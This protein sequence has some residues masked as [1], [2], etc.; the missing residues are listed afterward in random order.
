VPRTASLAR[1]IA[2]T[3]ASPTPSRQ[4]TPFMRKKIIAANWK[5]NMTSAEAAS[6]MEDLELEL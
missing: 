5:M 3:L 6:F 4:N 1:Q 2:E